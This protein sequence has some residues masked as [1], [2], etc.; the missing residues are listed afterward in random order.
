MRLIPDIQWRWRRLC[1]TSQGAWHHLHREGVTRTIGRIVRQL[2]G[3]PEHGVDAAPAAPLLAVDTTGK[4]RILIIDALMPDPSRDSGSLRLCHL[5]Q[6]LQDMG[7]AVE[8]MPD[9]LRAS[10]GEKAILAGIGIPTL[11][12]PDV[13]SLPGWLHHEGQSLA[14]VM[15]CRHY[16]ASTHLDLFRKHAPS[17][18][19]LFDTVDLHHIRE[20]RAAE[21]AGSARLQRQA[22]RTRRRELKLI[23]QSDL[24]LVV[25]PWE[26]TYLEQL[27]PDADIRLLSNIHHVHPHG[28]DFEDRQGMIFVGGWGHPPNRDAIDWLVRDIL[29]LIRQQLP[30]ITLHLVGDLPEDIRTPLEVPGVRIHGRVPDLEPLMQSSRLALAPLRYGA[31]VKGKIN[32]AMSHGVPV[33]ATSV[34]VEGMS[35]INGRDVLIADTAA[36]F[37]NAVVRVHGDKAL[38]QTLRDGGIENVRRH[39]SF[40]TAR[41]CLELA[42]DATRP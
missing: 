16:V 9:S 29:P 40:E 42:L 34:G 19:I 17:A 21:H 23:R 3:L 12:R 25:S 41:S 14:A 13:R 10:A 31:G 37:A 18:R 36:D 20:M 15:L 11:C 28:S 8:F 32:M 27:A 4:P 35:L 38:W 6:I 22:R 24:T 1:T 30:D 7:W 26:K 39:F 33:V 2:R 5:M